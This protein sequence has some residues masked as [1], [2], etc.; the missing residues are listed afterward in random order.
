MLQA[1]IICYGLHTFSYIPNTLFGM[2]RPHH[3]LDFEHIIRY[4]LTTPAC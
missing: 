4:V 1:H 3:F 2:F